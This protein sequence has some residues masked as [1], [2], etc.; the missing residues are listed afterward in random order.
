MAEHNGAAPRRLNGSTNGHVHGRLQA[1]AT[2]SSS[3]HWTQPVVDYQQV[4]A[5]QGRVAD[6]LAAWLKTHDTAGVQ[7]RQELGRQLIADEISAIVDARAR[8]GEPPLPPAG[9]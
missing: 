1:M 4:Y 9:E 3:L 7:D 8:R 2:A 6:K 5:I